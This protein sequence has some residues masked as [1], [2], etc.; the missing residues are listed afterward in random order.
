MRLA[1]IP[2]IA[3]LLST[4]WRRGIAAAA[5]PCRRPRAR[6][7]QSTRPRTVTAGLRTVVP[8]I[9]AVS[10]LFLAF[11]AATSV[12]YTPYSYGS[13]PYQWCYP[14]NT[15]WKCQQRYITAEV[16][17][18]PSPSQSAAQPEGVISLSAWVQI[19]NRLPLG[20][21]PY[22]PASTDPWQTTQ[23]HTYN[24][25]GG[26]AAEAALES[27]LWASTFDCGVSSA[28]HFWHWATLG[29]SRH[30]VLEDW[31]QVQLT[32][33]DTAPYGQS[34]ST[35]WTGTYCLRIAS[36]ATGNRW[37]GVYE[38]GCYDPLVRNA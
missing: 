22:K 38:T 25:T 15:W 1:H 11:G 21:Y 32:R 10:T 26:P 8:T 13:G 12:A 28:G 19:G 33:T 6:S 17:A 31:Y 7:P 5:R 14:H 29:G 20:V 4:S 2:D 35:G 37:Y 24:P 23:C 16:F 3:S 18:P 9:A 34:S 30:Y 27:G 36:D